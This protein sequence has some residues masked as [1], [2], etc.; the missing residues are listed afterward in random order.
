M[1]GSMTVAPR[2]GSEVA[3]NGV[4]AE[5]VRAIVSLVERLYFS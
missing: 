2:D 3:W 5:K 4:D 1:A